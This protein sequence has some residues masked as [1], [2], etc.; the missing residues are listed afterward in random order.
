MKRLKHDNILPFYGVST[1]I[2]D[3]SLVFPWY[4]NGN[5]K[6][7]LE[8]NPCINPCDLASIIKLT[9]YFLRS[10]RSHEQ[11]LGAVKGLLFLH[12]N[13]VVHGALRPVRSTSLSLTTFNA[14]KR[15][16]Y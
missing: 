15:V 2:S 6:Q 1:T 7:Y 11:L 4:R 14:T 10:H 5:I 9:V 13:E 8:K 3:L 16:T 12:S